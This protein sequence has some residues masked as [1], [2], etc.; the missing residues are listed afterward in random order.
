MECG[1]IVQIDSTFDYS[2]KMIF[3]SRLI[4]FS[5]C[6]LTVV[7]NLGVVESRIYTKKGET[8]LH[9]DLNDHEGIDDTEIFELTTPVKEKLK[10]DYMA[11]IKREI[12]YNGTTQKFKYAKPMKTKNL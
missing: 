11:P 1:I 5:L 3:F 8:I 10:L 2:N 4:F 7:K 9:L 6:F 12:R